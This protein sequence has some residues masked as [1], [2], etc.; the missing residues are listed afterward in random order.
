MSPLV[1]DA[2]VS[3]SWLLDDELAP[4]AA[5]ALGRVRTEGGLVPQLWHFEVRNAVL[6]AE[7]RG[8]LPEGG[9]QARLPFLRDLPILT[10]EEAD[11]ESTMS[12]AMTHAL[13]YYDALYL[14]LAS[15]SRLPLTTLDA[16][17]S[18]AALAEGLEVLER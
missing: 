13:S 8:R 6:V 4:E 17:L 10:D 16:G 14:E 12:L 1:L 5:V 2:S 9:A 11:L 18:R 15:R 3:A 7:R